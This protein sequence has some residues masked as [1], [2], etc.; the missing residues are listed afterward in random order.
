M[1]ARLPARLARR[2]PDVVPLDSCVPRP[3]PPSLLLF[4]AMMGDREREGELTKETSRGSAVESWLLDTV[5]L[6]RCRARAYDDLLDRAGV[7]NEQRLKLKVMR[8]VNFLSELGI[9][10]KDDHADILRHLKTVELDRETILSLLPIAPPNQ[11]P[12]RRSVPS[13]AV[14]E[15]LVAL[16]AMLASSLTLGPTS[17]NRTRE[18]LLPESPPPVPSISVPRLVDRQALAKKRVMQGKSV[19]ITGAAGSGKSYLLMELRQMLE[20]RCQRAAFTAPTGVAACNIEGMT[21]HSWAGIGIKGRLADIDFS[22]AAIQ[23]WR[24]T[25][26]LVIDEVSMVSMELF[27]LLSEAGSQIRG[28]P[29]PFGGLQVVLCGDFFQLPP[30][31]SSGFCFESKYWPQ[32]LGDDGVVVLKDC[33]RQKDSTFQRILNDLR[34]GVVSEEAKALLLS[35]VGA[36]LDD[37]KPT[38]LCPTNKQVDEIN[39]QR[40]QEI[41][42][43][44]KLYIA[45]DE[46]ETKY[47]NGVRAPRELWL[48]VGAQ[49]MLLKNI[50]VLEGLV[51]GTCGVVVELTKD[52]PVVEFTVRRGKQLNKI[53]RLVHVE[54]WRFYDDLNTG[55][56]APGV[57]KILASRTQLPLMLAW[58]ITIHKAQG[59]TIPHL[60]VSFAGI[61]SCGQA[62]VALSRVND[63]NSLSLTDFDES[64]VFVNEKV[65]SFYSSLG[66]SA[67]LF[68]NRS[69]KNKR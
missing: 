49:V 9:A 19:F 56:T 38:L 30:V 39:A 1:S 61:F 23:R 66:A 13:A 60:K 26:V 45:K 20:D 25:E 54:E 7:G 17:E 8:N 69:I 14:D 50:S 34:V 41:S 18:A 68:S 33:Y 24:N 10:D 67:E 55:I 15:Q 12:S 35:R 31:G 6:S 11:R 22:D 42:F 47:L 27:D 2:S 3:S 36:E 52:A 48:K 65:K 4:L 40:L 37:V 16:P 5:R 51:N 43:K 44:E 59:M 53:V 62:Y 46:G 64:R 57:R 32:L 63:L 58:A 21:I 29:R 28:D